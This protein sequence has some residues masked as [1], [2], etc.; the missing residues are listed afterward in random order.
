[1]L[2]SQSKV[3]TVEKVQHGKHKVSDR[4]ACRNTQQSPKWGRISPLDN[5]RELLLGKQSCYIP[6][7][8]HECLSDGKASITSKA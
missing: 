1:M 5:E 4:C 7:A 2:V 6:N 3:V 8:G